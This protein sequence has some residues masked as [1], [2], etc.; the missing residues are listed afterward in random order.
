MSHGLNLNRG[1]N[2]LNSAS[3]RIRVLLLG[4]IRRLLKKYFEKTENPIYVYCSVV[5]MH[6]PQRKLLIFK[7]KNI[8]G[9][10]NCFLS[11]FSSR[12]GSLGVIFSTL[13]IRIYYRFYA[14]C[15]KKNGSFELKKCF[16]FDMACG[17]FSK[18]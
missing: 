14:G 7:Y 9:L 11:H 16:I 3:G 10:I 18:T 8:E 1:S 15:P 2:S 13:Y 5:Y 6:Y 17:I 12:Q 4:I